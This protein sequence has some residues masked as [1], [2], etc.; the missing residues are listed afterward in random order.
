[1]KVWIN[2]DTCSSNLA[3]CESCFGQFL[4]TGV[5]DRGCIVAWRDD[6]RDDITVHMRTENES[7]FIVI[8]ADK[9]ELIAYEGWPAFVDFHPS[10]LKS[11]VKRGIPAGE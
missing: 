4:R 11:E 7:H 9:R 6:G 8:P 2:R 10:F 5:P 3:A 1:M